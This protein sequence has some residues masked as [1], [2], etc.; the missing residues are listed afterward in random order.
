MILVKAAPSMQ[1]GF[2][3]F[4]SNKKFQPK[5]TPP[6]AMLKADKQKSDL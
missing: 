1:L 3:A 2:A 6:S 4:L 5:I